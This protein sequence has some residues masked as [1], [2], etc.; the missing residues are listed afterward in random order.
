MNTNILVYY[1]WQVGFTKKE[2]YEIGQDESKINSLREMFLLG[3][4]FSLLW[5]LIIFI[6]GMPILDIGWVPVLGRILKLTLSSQRK[7]ARNDHWHL[8]RAPD[9]RQWD[10]FVVVV[11][12]L[13]LVNIFIWY[14]TYAAQGVVIS[15]FI[16][17]GNSSFLPWCLLK[18][19]YKSGFL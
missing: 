9:R 18:T 19:E 16:Y 7:N 3:V 11:Y 6:S 2:C 1:H 13:S 10:M 5:G 15:L 14:L 8:P 12:L 17:T 4:N